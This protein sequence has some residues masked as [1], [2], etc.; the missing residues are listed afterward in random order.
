ML[1]IKCCKLWSKIIVYLMLITYIFISAMYSCFLFK[2]T[3]AFP[4]RCLPFEVSFLLCMGHW[5]SWYHQSCDILSHKIL[6]KVTCSML[7]RSYFC[8]GSVHTALQLIQY[9]FFF[10]GTNALYCYDLSN[11]VNL[12]TAYKYLAPHSCFS[13]AFPLLESLVMEMKYRTNSLGYLIILQLSLSTILIVHLFKTP[14]R[15]DCDM[16]LGPVPSINSYVDFWLKVSAFSW[17][18]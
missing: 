14:D 5:A 12:C 8:P 13:G 15:Y 10:T 16:N 7:D 6:E 18:L 9:A 11:K 17:K 3:L 1:T 2:R 4:F